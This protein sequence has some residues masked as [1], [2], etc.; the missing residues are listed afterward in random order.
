[1]KID[2]G[3]EVGDPWDSR[4]I[5]KELSQIDDRLDRIE[6]MLKQLMPQYIP[7][8]NDPRKDPAISQEAE[9]IIAAQCTCGQT[10]VCL[11]HSGIIDYKIYGNT[12]PREICSCPSGTPGGVGNTCC[13][14]KLPIS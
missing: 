10:T 3:V 12:A 7:G 6:D 2:E 11:A 4:E 14:C 8:W 13:N 5:E 1:M 9:R